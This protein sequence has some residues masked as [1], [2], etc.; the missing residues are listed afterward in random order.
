MNEKVQQ[1][2]D[3][4]YHKIVNPAS[5]RRVDINGKTGKRVLK[6]YIKQKTGGGNFGRWIGSTVV[7][8]SAKNI[9]I[10]RSNCD[11]TTSVGRLDYFDI[12]ESI[13]DPIDPDKVLLGLIFVS[14]LP[15]KKLP[16]TNPPIS[17]NI[18]IKN[19]SSI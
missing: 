12:N 5:G 7:G 18:Q 4:N 9:G 6:N 16:K 19:T 8:R 3:N 15:L 17:E 11:A 10:R 1:D 2:I 14:F 13:N